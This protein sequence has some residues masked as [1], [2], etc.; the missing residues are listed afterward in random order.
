MILLLMLNT[1]HICSRMS[2]QMA[3]LKDPLRLSMIQH[4]RSMGRKLQSQA[5]GILKIFLG[6]T[7]ELNMLLNLLVFLQP[8]R[9][10][11]YMCLYSISL[12]DARKVAISA[13][14]ADAPM[15]LVGVNEMSCDPKMKVVSNAS[16][17][18]NFPTSAKVV[19]EGF[20]TIEGLM[21]T[22][23][24]MIGQK[25]VDV[26]E[27]ICPSPLSEHLVLSRGQSS[28]SASSSVA[29]ASEVKKDKE[30]ESTQQVVEGV[31]LP[32]EIILEILS[33]LPARFINRFLA[34]SKSW[35]TV[36]SSDK[37]L[38][39]AFAGFFYHTYDFFRKPRIMRCFASIYGQQTN[40][41]L[42]FLPKYWGCN[43][44][45]T[46]QDLLCH[47]NKTP[48]S[49]GESS[50][51]V[52]N[53]ATRRWVELPPSP[54]RGKIPGWAARLGFD[55]AVSPHFHVFEFLD[56][57]EVLTISGVNIYSSEVARWM[58]HK[59]RWNHA[60]GLPTD[61]RS[62]FVND[63]LHLVTH[64]AE[65]VS[66]DTKGEAWRVFS[67]L[68]V[69]FIGLS[70]GSLHCVTA[71]SDANVIVLCLEVYDSNTW[72]CKLD[73]SKR[74]LCD[75]LGEDWRIIGIHPDYDNLFLATADDT[76]LASCR[77]ELQQLRH[78]IDLEEEAQG[79]YFPYV[80]IFSEESPGLQS[81]Q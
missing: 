19:Y 32:P 59:S 61:S 37:K 68:T 40:P 56:E 72:F 27:G 28:A 7:L 34:M 42:D 64:K 18:N 70:Q 24:A 47:C 14:S 75:N 52:C 35:H 16:C 2:P 26:Q 46:C 29:G 9:K 41:S 38:R 51:I 78:I 67:G 73:I 23:Y 57:A 55:P 6:V 49:S 71:R 20:G 17:T 31:N 81:R 25:T 50:Y 69:Q 53:P 43:L 76:K 58:Q 62:V 5:K 66:V 77:M 33:R 4:W 65:L 15:F 11:R 1:W 30:E 54:T 79:Q 21:T 74:Q 36:I 8:S 10:H 45:D 39:Q 12:G 44:V 22:V 13:P 48:D 80:P 3:R 63:R 60:V